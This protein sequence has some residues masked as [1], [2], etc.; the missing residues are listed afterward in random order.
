M[1]IMDAEWARNVDRRKML[2]N[3]TKLCE[4]AIYS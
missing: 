4:K 1:L 3:L 2:K